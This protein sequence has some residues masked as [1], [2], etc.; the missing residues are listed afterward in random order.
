MD[1][2]ISVILLLFI[3]LERGHKLYAWGRKIFKHG[4]ANTALL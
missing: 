4:P 1:E 3:F 2:I